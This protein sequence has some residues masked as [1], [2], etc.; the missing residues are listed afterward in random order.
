MYI[1]ISGSDI[2]ALFDV[3]NIELA[4]LSEWL[5]AN[6]LTLN[7]DKTFYMRFQRK[8]IKTDKLKVTIG[9]DTLKQ[10]SQCKYLGLIIDNKL[11]WAAHIAHFK[12]KLSKCVGILIKAR[13]C[14]SRKC[15][16]DLYYSFAY[17]YLI[18]CVK[19]WGHA[20]DRLLHAIFLVQKKIERIITF[21]AFLA[22]RPTAPIF[23][24]LRFL[25]LNKIVSHRTS[26]FMFK[27]MN[28]MLPN[29][30]NSLIVRNNGTHNYNTKQ[31]HNLLYR[32]N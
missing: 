25:P 1:Y 13:P 24:N 31:N 30:M 12:S 27:L 8:S 20:G 9:Q 28:N 32:V 5:N 10:T 4:A 23:L 26:V 22:H 15:L 3:L 17:P 21:S 2:N 7:A 11:N 14:L 16:L 18:Y 29:A 19:L 6:R